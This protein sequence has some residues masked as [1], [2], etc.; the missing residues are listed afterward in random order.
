MKWE[1][2]VQGPGTILKQI[3]LAVSDEDIRLALRDG[4]FVLSG[5]RL[6]GLGDA[7]SV[8]HEAE[9]IVTLLSS[10]ARLSFGSTERLRVDDVSETTAGTFQT[11]TDRSPAPTSFDRPG[12]PQGWAQLSS[13]SRSVRS[14]LSNP[15]MEQALA[16][17]DTQ[18]P[19]WA[20][21]ARLYTVIEAELG[22]P[23]VTARLGLSE[24]ARKQLLRGSAP[25]PARRGTT[26]QAAGDGDPEGERL[27]LK[28]ALRSVDRLLMTWL[29]SATV[30]SGHD[31]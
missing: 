23:A 15:A 19:G 6:D 22:G 28:D 5:S 21:L 29:T 8:Q 12:A 10:S 9:R 24:S 2:R 13:V 18:A 4:A 30:P 26:P 1:V 25:P 11:S 20:D 27:T 17:R 7:A 14:A 3:A 31:R 16:L